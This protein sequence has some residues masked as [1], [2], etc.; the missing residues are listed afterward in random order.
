[1]R[2][3]QDGRP[4]SDRNALL[5]RLRA[6][7]SILD[8]VV[9]VLLAVMLLPLVIGPFILVLDFAAA[10]QYAAAG[11]IGA[12]FTCCTALAI[13]AVRRGEFGPAVFGAAL[14]L[15]ALLVIMAKRLPR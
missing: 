13:R 10:G 7:L 5:A 12:T 11:L 6:G 8:V 15:V 4:A 2:A 9:G 14:I 1:M 3:D